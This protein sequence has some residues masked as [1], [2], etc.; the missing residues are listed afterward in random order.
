MG[1]A[2]AL[3][4][5][6]VQTEWKL[7]V[8]RQAVHTGRAIAIL[9]KPALVEYSVAADLPVF[10]DKDSPLDGH[11]QRAKAIQDIVREILEMAKGMT[12]G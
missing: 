9:A 5:D 1:S 12:P 3:A 4:D 11:P 7:A 6:E 8:E 2:D 10:P